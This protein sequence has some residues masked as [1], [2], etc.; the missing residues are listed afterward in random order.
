M[1]DSFVQVSVLIVESSEVPNERTK[2][3]GKHTCQENTY[4]SYINYIYIYKNLFLDRRKNYEKGFN[5]SAAAADTATLMAE[6]E[7]EMMTDMFNKIATAC[8]KKCISAKY[9]DSEL[10][11]GEAVCLDRC[12]AKWTQ[13]HEQIGHRLVAV[14]MQGQKQQQL[15]EQEKNQ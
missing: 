10:S 8:H 5:M 13:I 15:V 3:K 1:Y 7:I 11:R 6:I 12:V 14:E 4:E 9:R 2:A